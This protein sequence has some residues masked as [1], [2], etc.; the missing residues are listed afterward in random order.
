[1]TTD[2]LDRL[3][4]AAAADL[5]ARTLAIDTE[6]ALAALDAP[7]GGR[8]PG[9]RPVRLLGRVGRPV[10]VGAAAALLV[11]A[12]VGAV[13]A[14][15]G[16]DDAPSVSSGPAAAADP[17]DFGPIRATLHG[18]ASPTLRADLHA[19][20][21]LQDGTEVA[22]AIS[23]GRPG[24]R[25]GASECAVDDPGTFNPAANCAAV[26]DTV[27]L[28][29]DGRGTLVVPTWAVF[30]PRS[31]SHLNDC[32]V[33]ACSLEVGPRVDER[34]PIQEAEDQT[35]GEV[36]GDGTTLPLTFAADLAL[37]PLPAL[38]VEAV[39]R[40]GDTLVVRLTGRNLEV[41]PTR[42]WLD[43]ATQPRTG[44]LTLSNGEVYRPADLVTVR[45]D[46]T[47]DEEVALPLTLVEDP[48]ISASDPPTPPV[49]CDVAPASCTIR[50]D[51]EPGADHALPYPRRLSAP[52]V[53]YPPIP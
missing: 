41:A 16:A 11:I 8:R 39:R 23:G 26:G 51:A 7:S 50:L 4:R 37:P 46:G 38:E 53:P 15:R 29:A 44:I 47:V 18:L 21:E 28:D 5:H 17:T 14:V 49:R 30:D 12:A 1:M 13:L 3:G 33:A 42:V 9:R 43:G 19:P 27:V 48:A 35:F 10:F 20:A 45:P 25:F 36:P 6:A 34:D 40:E 52:R 22:I 2:T 32:R 31:M 24:V